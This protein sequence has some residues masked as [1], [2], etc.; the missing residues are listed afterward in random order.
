MGREA[1][2]GVGNQECGWDAPGK[3]RG[4]W[5]NGS[6]SLL[7]QPGLAHLPEGWVSAGVEKEPCGHV[8]IR[9]GRKI[10]NA[11][12]RV[13]VRAQTQLCVLLGNFQLHPNPSCTSQVV[14]GVSSVGIPS[15]SRE[16]Q[17]NYPAGRP[18]CGS[19]NGMILLGVCVV[20][21]GPSE[22]RVGQIPWEYV[23]G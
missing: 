2:P 17:R 5:G 12:G 21:R 23:P 16:T 8:G 15:L 1:S 10:W 19:G 13:R 3:R 7:Q 9:G 18:G 22:P 6:S 4:M 14:P 20:S 11:K